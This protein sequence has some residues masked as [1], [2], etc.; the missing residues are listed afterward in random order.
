[1]QTTVFPVSIVTYHITIQAFQSINPLILINGASSLKLFYS[2]FLLHM[3]YGELN[4]KNLIKQKFRRLKMVKGPLAYMGAGQATKEQDGVIELATVAEVVAGTNDTKACTPLGVAAIAIAGAPAASTTQPGIIEIA[5]NG[6]ASAQTSSTLAI[7]PSNIPSIMAAP[8]AI[9]GG[10]PAA[11]NFTTL[12]MTDLV[13]TN[14][15]GVAE[16]GTNIASYTTGDTLYASGATTLSKLALGTARQLYQTNAGA[17]APEWASN[18]DVPGTLAVTGATTLDDTLAVAGAATTAAITASGLLTGSAGITVTGAAIN[19]GADAGAH[20]VNIGTGAAAKTITVGNSTGATAISLNAGTGAIN[21]G[22]NAIAHTVTVGNV[23]GATAVAVNAGT[24][25]IA[26]ASTGSGDITAA[27]ADTLLLD[28]AGV[29][30]LNSSAGAINIG[31]DAVAQAINVGTGA[32]ARTIT[33]GNVTGA[34]GLVLNSGTGGVAVNTTGAGDVVVASADTVLIDSAGVLEL[35]SSAGVISIGNDAVAQNINVG[36]GAAA[37]TVT[38]GNTTGATGVVINA[39]SAA[40]TV[41][42]NLKLN[43]AATQLQV[44]GGAATDFIGTGTLALGTATIL[45]TNIA[46]TDRIFIQR[47]G[48]NGS[49][50]LGEYTYSISAGVSFTITSVILGT[51]ASPQTAD[52]STFTYFIVRQI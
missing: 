22:T 51:P 16:G 24:G 14:P 26:L 52:V 40:T 3:S 25:G 43:T 30:E 27:S 47:V 37:R 48:I 17:T 50:T 20:A 28:S 1:L 15:L 39:G 32:A 12:T 36:T 44:H 8:G 23:T 19:L 18:I 5:T 2:Y 6:E 35:N 33:V 38:I 10:T 13:L 9:G 31:N 49:A 45:N 42:T 11:G 46:A 34:T 41:N 21:I 7:V 4:T 29:L